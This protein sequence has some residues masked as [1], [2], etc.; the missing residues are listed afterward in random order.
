MATLGC[1]LAAVGSSGGTR[2]LVVD[3]LLERG[4]EAV[5]ARR[6]HAIQTAVAA[7]KVLTRVEVLA[8]R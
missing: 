6:T 5:A 2:S 3:H 8:G 1:E 7:A 4:A